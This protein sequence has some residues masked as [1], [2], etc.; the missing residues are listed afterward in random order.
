MPLSPSPP[1]SRRTIVQTVGFQMIVGEMGKGAQ[2]GFYRPCS[3]AHVPTPATP[4]DV[5]SFSEPVGHISR[6]TLS[7]KCVCKIPGLRA[8][9]LLTKK[10]TINWQRKPFNSLSRESSHGGWGRDTQLSL[11]STY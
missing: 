5:A 3:M 11:L 6:K 1:D 10:L 4:P 9:H 2:G 8:T 7:S